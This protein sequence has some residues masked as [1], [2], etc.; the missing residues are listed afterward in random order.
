LP[1]YPWLTYMD[2]LG[3]SKE[4]RRLSSAGQLT[5][6]LR[7]FMGPRKRLEELYDIAVDPYELE[8]L[9]DDPRHQEVLR[10]LRDE[11]FAWV[12][13]TR[14]TGFIPEQML[15][16]FAQGSSEYEYARS[17]SYH[18]ERC[19]QAVRLMEQ[20][21]SAL[22]LIERLLK[23]PYGPVRYWAAAGLINLGS[24]AQSAI[25]SLIRV[26]DDPHPEVAMIAAEALCY[27]GHAGTALPILERYLQDDRQLVCI[28]AANVISRI[29]EQARPLISLIRMQ[30][31]ASALR[32]DRFLLMV[33]WLMAQTLRNL[34]EPVPHPVIN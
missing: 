34:G 33:D 11:H 6:G 4:L 32:P 18:L 20:G 24:Q 28:A 8:N 13:D 9:V 12:R 15:R 26:L 5:G 23:D 3:T 17:Q 22:P 19:I 30:S 27:L 21:A 31:K 10:R 1:H 7:Y 16:D 25:P 2:L 14:D 29:G